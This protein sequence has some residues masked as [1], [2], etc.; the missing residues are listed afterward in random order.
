MVITKVS[1]NPINRPFKLDFA[2]V[3]TA[4]GPTKIEAST[5]KAAFTLKAAYD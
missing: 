4:T 5:K 3:F 2:I 1:L